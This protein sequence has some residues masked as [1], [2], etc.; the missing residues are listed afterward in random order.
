MKNLGI[1]D[2]GEFS[3]KTGRFSSPRIFNLI[4]SFEAR[5][6]LKIKTMKVVAS[7]EAAPLPEENHVRRAIRDV[8]RWEQESRRVQRTA[9]TT[10]RLDQEIKVIEPEALESEMRGLN[11]DMILIVMRPSA[12]RS[13][14]IENAAQFV[15]QVIVFPPYFDEMNQLQELQSVL[16][17]TAD[18]ITLWLPYRYS[19]ACREILD[20]F[21]VRK[22]K[23]IAAVELSVQTSPYPRA[24]FLNSYSLPFVDLLVLIAGT[25]LRGSINYQFTD[26]L[27]LFG[28]QI[29]HENTVPVLSS[30]VLT[31]AGGA[32]QYMES[33][34]ITVYSTEQEHIQTVNTFTGIIHRK[35]G[36]HEYT[37]VSHDPSSADLTGYSI[38]L[39][40][41]L[42][43]GWEQDEEKQRPTLESFKSTQLVLDQLL[44][45]DLLIN[46]GRTELFRNK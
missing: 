42:E 27:P 13:R 37:E 21:S 44:D 19:V 29:W 5:G 17:K 25:P 24:E 7:A 20:R 30:T 2:S 10:F 15:K 43:N 35:A 40:R 26:G 1:L 6:D 22:G 12:T 36:Y 39:N 3:D 18:R 33:G 11:L 41:C 46:E 16:G 28:M 31:T 32:L 14:F 4:R 45:L 34:K 8:H 38:L 9:T 23:R